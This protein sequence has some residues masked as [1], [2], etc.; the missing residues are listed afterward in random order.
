MSESSFDWDDLK[1]ILSVGR[2][3]SLALAARELGVN[4]STVSRRIA[5][6]EQRLGVKL[7][8][9]MQTGLSPT[10]AGQEACASAEKI[11][12]DIFDLSRTIA[13][14]DAVLKGPLTITAPQLLIE[15]Q[16][17]DIADKFIAQ[18]PGIDIV[19]NASN[20]ILNLHKREADIAIRVS[21]HP[22]EGLY[23]RVAARQKRGFY[24]SHEYLA[25][26]KERAESSNPEID[27]VAFSWWGDKPLKDLQQ[28]FSHV[29]TSVVVDDMIA[30]QSMVRA[31]LGI[32]RMPC[33][34]GDGDPKLTRVPELALEPYL[35]I[36]VL[37]HPDLKH[38]A[39][40]RRFMSFCADEIK[41][42]QAFYLGQ[43]SRG[44]E[45][46]RETLPEAVI[47]PS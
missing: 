44:P 38:N 3:G 10:Q 40:V 32:G 47:E 2:N 1:F 24:G 6:A 35:D 7:F 9:R 45:A 4:H 26:Y 12:Q 18:Y 23:G 16:I 17:A 42:R 19:V 31:G 33:F 5:Q 41:K 43:E 14:R 11:E 36:W 46:L 30:M 27:Y 8:N 34:V 39:R 13:A 20:E 37:S 25:R 22:A 29:R 15:A 21:N 28:Y